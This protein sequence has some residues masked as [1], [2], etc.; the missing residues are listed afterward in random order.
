MTGKSLID[1][2]QASAAQDR[3]EWRSKGAPSLVPAGCPSVSR[4][5][6]AILREDL[7]NEER[8]AIE[9]STEARKLWDRVRANV[10]Y[11]SKWQLFQYTRG[12]LTGADKRD[13]DFHLQVDRCKRSLWLVQWMSADIAVVNWVERLSASLGHALEQVSASFEDAFYYTRETLNPILVTAGAAGATETAEHASRRTL[14]DDGN[15]SILLSW[16]HGSEWLTLHSPK[17]W[18]PGT[19]VRLLLLDSHG[20]IQ[21]SRFMMLRDDGVSAKGRVRLSGALPQECGIICRPVAVWELGDPFPEALL[22]DF[23]AAKADDPASVAKWKGWAEKA[24]PEDL[25]TGL[26]PVL[27]DIV[28]SAEE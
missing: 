16:E 14:F 2:L 18:K 4:M 19:L 5:Y 13:I 6:R 21:A 17:K 27:E 22:T 11:P 23:R 1:M 26:A 25:P 9:D 8:K 3:Q 10:W 12:T 28:G 7:T 24:L 15:L 20:T